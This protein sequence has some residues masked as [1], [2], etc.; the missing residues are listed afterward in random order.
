MGKVKRIPKIEYT[1]QDILPENQS[2]RPRKDSVI[3]WPAYVDSKLSRSD[4]RRIPSNLA[5]PDVTVDML[6]QAAEMAKLEAEIE[7]GKRYPREAK[8]RGGYLV[9]ENPDGHKKKRLL[10][11]L[12]KGL[13][14]ISAQREA[15]RQ[16]AAKKKTKKGRGKR[17]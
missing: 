13:R 17:R 9:I 5:A 1:S 8:H 7:S 2:M 14:R 11:M 4:G 15:A 10:L 12:A 3:I 16:A 6:L